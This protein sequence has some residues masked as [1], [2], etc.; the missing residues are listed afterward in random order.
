M[1]TS[2]W[3]VLGRGL[4]FLDLRPGDL[5]G[6]LLLHWTAGI[7]RLLT[8]ALW[9]PLLHT[10]LSGEFQLGR[11]LV[12]LQGLVP[13]DA[14]RT[15]VLAVLAV[16]VAAA[17]LARGG[18][19][20]LAER[21][22]S[23]RVAAGER[24]LGAKLV[25]RHL[26]F[27]QGYFDDAGPART[28]R[29]LQRLPARTARLSRWVVRAAASSLEFVLHA[30]LLVVLAPLLGSLALALLAAYYFGFR[31][32]VRRVEARAI[33]DEDLDD[34]G[35]SEAHDLAS[36]FLLLRL[37]T[38]SEQAVR[39]FREGSERRAV[40][41]RRRIG[42]LSLLDEARQAMNVILLLLFVL[43]AG[44][45]IRQL[46]AAAVSRYLVF[47]FVFRRSMA[48]FS[49]LQRMPAQWRGLRLRVV[50]VGN[51]LAGA[52]APVIEPGDRPMPPIETGLS[53]RNLTFGFAEAQPVLRDVSMAAPCGAL[54]VVVGPNGSGKSTLLKLV[55]R[56]YDAPPGTLLLD[57]TDIRAFDLDGLRS[58]CGFAG[59]EPMLLDA[60]L[61]DNL[62][63]GLDGASEDRLWA[64][65][66]RAGLA[67]LVKGLEGGFNHRIGSSGLRLSQGERQRVALARVFLRDPA[68]MLLDEAMSSF[69]PAAEA[70]AMAGLEAFAAGRVVLV[71]TH[72]L[73]AIPPAAQVIVLDEGRIVEQ[74]RCAEL[75]ARPGLFRRLWKPLA[76]T[77]ADRVVPSR[78]AGAATAAR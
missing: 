61:R 26:Q 36:N 41:E 23:A 29:A 50:E 4:A 39:I 76:A 13:D 68:I 35:A 46:D 2:A 58:R 6:P 70:V 22:M 33:E 42:M 1:I 77:Q 57:G 59:P 7:L 66:E 75:L 18:V 65:A 74:G 14:S 47:F 17:A 38:P 73:A 69:D 51:L 49:A 31:R 63:F 54:T 12:F 25:R 40:I 43:G 27:G 19:A 32:I 9:V 62:C 3:Q 55:L 28:V 60:S 64:A 48:S 45:A 78:T 30:A 11:R 37:N 67:P 20:Y 15:N 24:A 5:A 71:V 16:A 72:R 10:V 44:L 21:A 52:N 53:V 34:E 8:L 56:L